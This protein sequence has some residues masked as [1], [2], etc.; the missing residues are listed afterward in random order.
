MNCDWCLEVCQQR[1]YYLIR[2]P[3]TEIFAC[4][5]CSNLLEEHMKQDHF[6]PWNCVQPAWSFNNSFKN[7]HYSIIDRI[8]KCKM[9]M[10]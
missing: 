10:G 9:K 5:K 3:P 8:V 6:H 4:E 2:D 7:K 1:R